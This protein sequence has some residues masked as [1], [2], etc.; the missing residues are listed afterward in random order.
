[1][2][3]HGENYVANL[4]RTLPNTDY[5]W[6]IFPTIASCNGV[7]ANTATPFVVLSPSLGM[8][9]IEVRDWTEIARVSHSALDIKH[10]D[11]TTTSEASPLISA[12]ELVRCLSSAVQERYRHMALPYKHHELRFPASYTV[13]LPNIDQAVI[14]KLESKGLVE[15]GRVLSKQDLTPLRFERALKGLPFTAQNEGVLSL[16]TLDVIR[17]VLD[18]TLVVRDIENNDVGTLTPEQAKLVQ[19]E[20]ILSAPPR[21]PES[22]MEMSMPKEVLEASGNLSVR[23]VRGVAGSGKSLVLAQ[24]A[25]HLAETYPDQKLLI[26]AYSTDL[27]LDLQARIEGAPNLEITSFSDVC[28]RILGAQFSTPVSIQMW[29]EQNYAAVRLME[30]NGFTADFVAEEIEWRKEL[31]IYNAHTYMEV[32]REGRIRALSRVKRAAI[33]SLFDLYIQG[34]QREGLFDPSDVSYVALNALNHAHPM[35]HYYDAILIDEAQDFAPSWIAIVKRLLNPLG[36]MFL[37]DDPTQSLF[38]SFSWRRRGVDVVGH[39]RILR[40]PF[41][42]T[43]AIAKAAYSL[44]SAD[45]ILNRSRDIP[46]PDMESYRLAEGDTPLLCNCQD[47]MRELRLIERYAAQLRDSGI[48]SGEI[49]ILCHR[50]WMEKRWSHLRKE[51]YYVKSFQDMKGLEFQAVLIPQLH[52]IFE[53]DNS[54]KDETF[55]SEMR[56]RLF[57]AMTRAREILIMSYI[58][59]LPDAL[60]PIMPYVRHEMTRVKRH[61]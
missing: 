19:E 35:Y 58:Q 24:R 38:R 28:A 49:A 6:H 54:L 26:M 34:A 60:T 23:L 11:G 46:K 21:A 45:S 44:V 3:K 2:A 18:P 48:P 61:A 29:L 43:Q 1:M 37:C 42:N 14:E 51:G 36:S 50:Q 30:Q 40:I 20:L 53:I 52:S 27:V 59:A 7:V 10:D 47:A 39:T 9:I 22:I 57:T 33:N 55:I 56:R 8:V 4:L 25:Q 15:Q 31:N 41:R 32:E 17:G 13:A 5:V 12:Q 16:D